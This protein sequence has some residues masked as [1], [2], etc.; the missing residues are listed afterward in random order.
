MSRRLMKNVSRILLPQVGFET[1]RE[2]PK[3]TSKKVVSDELKSPDITIAI[4]SSGGANM[5]S[6]VLT[7]LVIS[8]LSTESQYQTLGG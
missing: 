2:K 7:S 8:A 4:D 6:R 5:L 1:L 3:S